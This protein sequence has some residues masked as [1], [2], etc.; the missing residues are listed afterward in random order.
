MT[1]ILFGKDE[2]GD[3]VEIFITNRLTGLYVVG[4]NGTGKSTLLENL[5]FRDIEA[6]RGV[7]LLDPQ[8]D[9]N[10]SVLNRIPKERLGG[11]MYLD[12][13]QERKRNNDNSRP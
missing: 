12:P 4:A 2:H 3:N 11:V 13:L 9:W 8:G 6:G 7:C 5:I 10:N 1:G